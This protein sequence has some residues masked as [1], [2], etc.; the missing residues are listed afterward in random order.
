MLIAKDKNEKD[1]LAWLTAKIEKPS[2]YPEFGEKIILPKRPIVEHH[3]VHK[4]KD[5]CSN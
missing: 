4:V 1:C 5:D 3:F 2:F